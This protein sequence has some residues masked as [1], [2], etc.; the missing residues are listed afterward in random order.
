MNLPCLAGGALVLSSPGRGFNSHVA[1][2]SPDSANHVLA[3]SL[4]I[5]IHMTVW[6]SGLRRWLQ[7]PVRKGVGSNPTAVTLFPF[8]F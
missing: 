1:H 3:M 5:A 4:L 6:P 8:G 2:A 7:A